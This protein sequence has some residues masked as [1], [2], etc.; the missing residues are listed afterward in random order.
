MFY[1]RGTE[2]SPVWFYP[3]FHGVD[4]GPFNSILECC[5]DMSKTASRATWQIEI[6]AELERHE[7]K[8]ENLETEISQLESDAYTWENRLEDKDSEL[9]TSRAYQVVQAERIIDLEADLKRIGG[10]AP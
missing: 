1:K 8:V 4:T 9:I 5:I 7:R 2:E 3:G 6:I 10:I